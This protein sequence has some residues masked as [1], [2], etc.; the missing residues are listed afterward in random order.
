MARTLKVYTAQTKISLCAQSQVVE[1]ALRE[2]FE[3]RSLKIWVVSEPKE[4]D[5][6]TEQQSF[7]RYKDISF[8]E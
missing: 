3:K 6:S 1:E 4:S 2:F 8:E 5:D 7:S